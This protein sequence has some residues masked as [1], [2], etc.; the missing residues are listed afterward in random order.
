VIENKKKETRSQKTN[1][2]HPQTGRTG[3]PRR[4]PILQG[5]WERIVTGYQKIFSSG[6]RKETGL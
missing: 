2:Q 1:T 3:K 6:G 5:G 4:E